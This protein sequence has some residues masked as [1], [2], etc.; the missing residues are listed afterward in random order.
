MMLHTTHIQQLEQ[1]LL[2][3]NGSRPWSNRKR[4]ILTGTR[5]YLHLEKR[6]K[7]S[8]QE[9]KKDKKTAYD[10]S[11]DATLRYREDDRTSMEALFI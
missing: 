8:G 6:G 9:Y 4:L 10:S 1:R 3:H 7:V 2:Q 11:K 5:V